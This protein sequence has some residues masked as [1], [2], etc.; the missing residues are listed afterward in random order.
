MKQGTGLG[1]FHSNRSTS[2][3]KKSASKNASCV[4]TIRYDTRCYFNVRSK[5]DMSRL[6]LPHGTSVRAERRHAQRSI[7][8][9]HK[10]WYIADITRQS[11]LTR[12]LFEPRQQQYVVKQEHVHVDSF[13]Y[14]CLPTN[15]F[16][17][18]Y[19]TFLCCTVSHTYKQNTALFCTVD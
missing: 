13:R 14:F 8:T 19:C 7:W 17:N 5:A 2:C 6:N 12:G 10:Q 3:V 16:S 11:Y 4:L 9:V 15:T 1:Q 18:N